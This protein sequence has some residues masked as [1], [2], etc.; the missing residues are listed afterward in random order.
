MKKFTN[1]VL[2]VAVVVAMFTLTSRS[3][4]A[5]LINGTFEDTLNVAGGNDAAHRN[6]V[7]YYAPSDIF[8][9]TKYNSHPGSGLSGWDV[10]AG[11]VDIVN[12]SATSYGWDGY[13]GSHQSLDL[14][15]WDAGTIS[16]SFFVTPGETADLFFVYA[17]NPWNGGTPSMDVTIGGNT[18]HYSH[19]GSTL[20]N[21]A[22]N[23]ADISF[24]G[25]GIMTVTFSATSGGTGGVVLDAVSIP[26][27]RPSALVPE[28][29]T[30]AL[31]GLGLALCAFRRRRAATV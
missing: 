27:A 21:M 26:Q 13:N 4:R 28:P 1:F 2:S 19:T 31:A 6:F 9:P 14:N 25:A 10:V 7:D 24:V 18:Y 15:G 20:A 12:A 8:A 23:L 11:S 5:D 17:N 30:M 16:Q 3:V 22:W 29:A